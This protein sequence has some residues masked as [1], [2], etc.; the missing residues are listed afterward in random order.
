ML[1]SSEVE[2]HRDTDEAAGEQ[3]VGE[4]MNGSGPL[5]AAD[6]APAVNQPGGAP[7]PRGPPHAP[8]P[9]TG[10]VQG[11]EVA[12]GVVGVGEGYNSWDGGEVEVSQQQQRTSEQEQDLR[13]TACILHGSH[14][15]PEGNSCPFCPLGH[16]YI[17]M[18]ALTLGPATKN[19]CSWGR[20]EA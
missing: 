17:E 11:G 10:G 20:G 6:K 19:F 8:V 4:L 2:P 18:A 12:C 5:G 3:E 7:E 9:H 16:A 14:F 1:L 13:D 15:L